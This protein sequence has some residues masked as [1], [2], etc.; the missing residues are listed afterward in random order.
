MSDPV[1]QTE[2]YADLNL[3]ILLNHAL[4]RL[5]ELVRLYRLA[6]HRA[7]GAG[8]TDEAC[9]FFTQ[10]YVY[11]LESGDTSRANALKATLKAYGRER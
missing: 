6:G 10:A 5:D 4:G 1:I 9:F 3:E 8:R 11:A 7:E 2:R